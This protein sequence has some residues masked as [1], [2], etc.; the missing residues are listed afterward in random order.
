MLLKAL[1]LQGFKSFPDKTTLE[2]GKGITAVIGPNGSGK[3]NISDAVRW[4]LGEQ[5]SKSLRGSKMEDVIF[6]GTSLRKAMGFAEVTLRLDNADRTLNNCDKDEVSVTRRYY[7]SG[8]SEYQLN[9]ETVRLRDIHELFMDTGLGRD[10]YSMVSQGRVADLISS[11]SPQR[12]DMLEEAAG[13]SH[14]RYRR[15]DATRRLEQAEENLVRLR[16]ILTELEGRVGPLK[17]QSEKAQK[18]LVLAG[19]K[20]E[21]EIGLWLK[22][23]ERSREGLRAQEDKIS[24][25]AA[26]Y[27][28]AERELERISAQIEELMSTGSGITVQI[29]ELR[30]KAASDEEQATAVDG[31]IAVERNNLSHNRETIERIQRDMEAA[32][33]TEQHLDDQITAAEKEIAEINGQIENCR[34][35]LLELLD[36]TGK[37]KEQESAITAERD[38]AEAQAKTVNEALSAARIEQSTA[39]S[40]AEEIAARMSTVDEVIASRG[41]LL[42]ALREQAEVSRK[43]LDACLENIESLSNSIDGYSM[44]VRSRAEKAEKLRAAGV[45]PQ[46]KKAVGSKFFN[47]LAGLM[48]DEFMKRGATLHGCDVRT[49]DA[50]ANMDIAGYNYG[51][52]R[53]KHDLKKYPNRLILGSETF[54][55]DAYRFREQAKKNPRLVGDFVWAGMDYLGEVGVGSWE[56]KA[57]ATQFSG[58]G[59]TTA[60]SGRIDLN[61]RPL[62]EALYTRV[63]LEQ[64]IGPYIA[65]RPVMFSG[66][67][68]SPSAWKMTDA[69]PSWS[70]AGCEGKKAHIEVYARAA[71]VAL[72]L[73]GKKVAEKQLKNDCLAKFT[74]P[75]KSGTLEAVSYDAIDRVLGRC[76]LQTAGADTVLRAVPEEKK[77]KP[78]R[79]CYIRIRY[80]DRAG[81]LKPMERGM[82]NITVSGGKLLAAGSACPFHPG[83]YLTPE[84]DTYY[85]EALAVVEAGESGAVEVSISDGER[86]DTVKIPIA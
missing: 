31:R 16:D 77:T 13:I 36:S 52:Y 55:N 33:A 29:E 64:E 62:G 8:E 40:S 20:K 42:D 37:L 15:A 74:I 79:L 68:H 9:G 61:G 71:K 32:T 45:Q 30:T 48:G 72:L 50:F 60:G 23:I 19:E 6:G 7:R 1:E 5:S 82:V 14:F 3:S 17:T 11:R 83:S 66:E 24:L 57:Y 59:W 41:G 84:T 69:M 65:V 2:F 70:W 58:L 63:A 38:S 76:K 28:Q 53:Y 35:Q 51:I 12:R 75:Y 46:K 34:L 56:Y 39:R 18:F 27:E 85:G 26:D 43:N 21:L 25:A 86:S 49:R 78:G 73:N 80:T 81:E 54:C 44:I 4:V 47:D 10:G 22:T 67:K